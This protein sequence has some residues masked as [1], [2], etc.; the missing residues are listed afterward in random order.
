MGTVH[1][2]CIVLVLRFVL[3]AD[4]LAA[5]HAHKPRGQTARRFLAFGTNEPLVLA[6]ASLQR[7]SRAQSLLSVSSTSRTGG[8]AAHGKPLGAGW[9]DSFSQGESNYDVDADPLAQRSHSWEYKPDNPYRDDSVVHKAEWYHESASAGQ[10]E[11]WQTH[12]P[13]LQQ[14]IAGREVDPGQWRVSSGGQWTQEYQV[15]KGAAPGPPNAGWFDTSV[16]QLDGFGRAKSPGLDSPKLYLTTTQERSVNTTLTCRDA[17][18]VGNTTLQAFDGSTELAVRCKLSMYLHA[19]D[20]DDQYSGE[21]ITFIKVNGV[22]VNT[23]CFPMVSGCNA[24]TQAPLFPCLQDLP[25]D[26]IIDSTGTLNISAQ[27]SDVVDECPYDG[28]LLSAVPMVT[29][30]IANKSIVLEGPEPAKP[31]LPVLPTPPPDATYFFIT[32]P[33]QCPYRGCVAHADL[34]LGE[35]AAKRLSRCALSMKIYQTDFDNEEGTK[36]ALEYIQIGGVPVVVDAIPGKNPCRSAWAGRPLS[37]LQTEYLA[38]SD[39]DV[40]TNATQGLVSVAVKITDHVDECAHDGYLLDGLVEMNCTVGKNGQA[41]STNSSVNASVNASTN[42]SANASANV[43][44]SFTNA[45]AL[46]SEVL[47]SSGTASQPT[48]SAAATRKRTSLREA[49]LARLRH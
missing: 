47:R 46:A 17:G 32:A 49:L 31:A 22:T 10:K 14:G 35:E 26:T 3:L 12:Y 40:T 38:L 33:L 6:Q 30:L 34:A 29:C 11:A 27:I 8:K 13:E 20:F 21:R 1:Q 18:C 19:T 28:N 5:L 4:L 9:F 16:K 7:I 24:S 23:D 15:A 2:G 45:S 48:E 44:E 42:V 41:V 37:L 36:E 25:L 39:H 43:S